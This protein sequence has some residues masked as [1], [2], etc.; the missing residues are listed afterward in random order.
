VSKLQKGS[1]QGGEIMSMLSFG[2]SSVLFISSTVL[3]P[4]SALMSFSSV[5]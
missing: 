1:F 3:F 4:S 5:H 2:V